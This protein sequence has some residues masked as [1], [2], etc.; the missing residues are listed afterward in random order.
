M[1]EEVGIT[2]KV[3]EKCIIRGMRSHKDAKI[4]GQ[5]LICDNFLVF[6]K[7]MVAKNKELEIEAMKDLNKKTN[8]KA[9]ANQI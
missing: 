4:F 7:H 6:K 9:E 8:N 3:L 2:E 5:V 1:I